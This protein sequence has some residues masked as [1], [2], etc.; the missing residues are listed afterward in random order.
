MSVSVWESQKECVK[1]WV[2]NMRV[3]AR[4]NVCVGICDRVRMCVYEYVRVSERV[5][6]WGGDYDRECMFER[7]WD[8]CVCVCEFV[9][10]RVW[11]WVRERMCVCLCERETL[12]YSV[13]ISLSHREPST[14]RCVIYALQISPG[15]PG[16]H[17]VNPESGCDQSVSGGCHHPRIIVIII[18]IIIIIL[19]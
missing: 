5:S 19:I 7:A 18:I 1:I 12:C 11:V 6:A 2:W 9:N 4:V 13:V 17:F 14:G 10:V 8:V 16:S 15:I 3:R